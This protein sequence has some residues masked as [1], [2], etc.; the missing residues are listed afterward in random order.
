MD[1]LIIATP[2]YTHLE[3]LRVALE[4]GK[5]ILLE[6]PMATTVDDADEIVQL[7]R[8][9]PAILQVGLQYRFKPII[10]EAWLN[11]FFVIRICLFITT[12]HGGGSIANP[13]PVEPH[14]HI[15]A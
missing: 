7:A 14:L 1:G 12:C 13:T 4:S 3:V 8:H 10:V 9:Y 6:K 2:N 5:H 11:E 15:Y